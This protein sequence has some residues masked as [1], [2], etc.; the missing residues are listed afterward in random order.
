MTTKIHHT[1]KNIKFSKIKDGNNKKLIKTRKHF[2]YKL[3]KQPGDP[4]KTIN[5]FM[6]SSSIGVFNLFTKN[7]NNLIYKFKGATAKGLLTNDNGKDIMKV[8]EEYKKR[9]LNNG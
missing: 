6:G 3:F 2:I 1:R 4:K 7:T 9:S 8:L 5:L